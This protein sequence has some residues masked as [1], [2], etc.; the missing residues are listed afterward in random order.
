MPEPKVQSSDKCFS[1]DDAGGSCGKGYPHSKAP[2]SK[3]KPA[4]QHVEIETSRGKVTLDVDELVP[5]RLGMIS[6]PGRLILEYEVPT[7]G[8]RAHHCMDVKVSSHADDT[9]AWARSEVQRLLVAHHLWLSRVDDQQLLRFLQKI[10]SAKHKTLSP[11][12][13]DSEN[14][15]VSKPFS[16]VL[17]EAEAKEMVTLVLGKRVSLGLPSEWLQAWSFEG[18]ALQS[19]PYGVRQAEGGPCGIVAPVQAFLLGSLIDSHVPPSDA[20][21][22]QCQSAL[23]DAMT[24][25]LYQCAGINDRGKAQCAKVRVLVPPASLDR[26]VAAKRLLR[27]PEGCTVMEFA[28]WTSLRA[29]WD[30]E[31]LSTAYFHNGTDPDNHSAGVIL[32]L[33]SALATRGVTQVRSDADVPDEVVMI[34]AHGYCSQEAVNLL[35]TGFATS[36]VFNDSKRLGSET[37]GESLL[38]RGVQQ[39]PKVGFLSLFEAFGSLEVGSFFKDPTW[40]VWV[41]HAESHY[42]VLFAGPKDRVEAGQTELPEDG[43]VTDVWYYDP[44]GRQ[45]EEKRITIKPAALAVKPDEDDLETNGMIA[46]CIRTRWG[47]MADLDWNGAEPI[48]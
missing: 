36:N 46:K 14:K 19:C 30:M 15:H 45:D 13:A 27:G 2:E 5:K 12:S 20:T 26:T 11:S 38:L 21:P 3:G 1:Q 25:C 18:D 28:D 37:S 6:K 9:D 32:F 10:Q 41:I 43:A 29:A 48:Y 24:D 35:L 44:L 31:P 7:R 47:E 23:R 42:S 33:Y 40:P 17:S 8:I 4:G 34:A 22:E 16:S 39:R